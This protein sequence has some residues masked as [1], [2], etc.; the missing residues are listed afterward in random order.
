LY[1]LKSVG[2]TI[3]NGKCYVLNAATAAILLD[4]FSDGAVGTGG[5]EKLNLCLAHL[6]EGGAHVL[7]LYFLDSKAFETKK[8]LIE[9]YSLV[10][11][12]DCYT[13][14]FDV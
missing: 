11:A 6:E 1:L 8:F 7:I 9:R 12:C 5:L 4:E 13:N 2:N 3:F 10:K 14:V